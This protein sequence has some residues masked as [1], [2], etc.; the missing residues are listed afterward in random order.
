MIKKDIKFTLF[1]LFLSITC[2]I[3]IALL[4]IPFVDKLFEATQEKVFIEFTENLYQKTKANSKSIAKENNT[5]YIYDINKDFD[6]NNLGSFEG[7]SIVK[8]NIIYLYIHN[9]NYMLNNNGYNS[10]NS[11]KDSIVEYDSDKYNID[12]FLLSINCQNNEYISK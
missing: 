6:Y 3:I 9:Q 8:N 7:Y 12:D 10:K 1:E 11:I 4:I 5:C 2:I